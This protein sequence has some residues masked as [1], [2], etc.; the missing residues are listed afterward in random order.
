M[1]TYFKIL[2]IGTVTKDHEMGS[3]QEDKKQ[4][5]TK[6]KKKPTITVAGSLLKIFH[7]R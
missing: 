6:K 4:S 3:Y 5:E 7:L 2:T 1:R